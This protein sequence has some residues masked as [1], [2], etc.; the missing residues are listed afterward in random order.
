LISHVYFCR[1][2]QSIF[3]NLIIHLLDGLC[4]F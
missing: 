3:Q 4:S 2:M 1:Q